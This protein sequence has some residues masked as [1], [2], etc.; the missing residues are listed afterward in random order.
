MSVK[1]KLNKAM[2]VNTATLLDERGTTHG[3]FPQQAT[4]AQC[5]K[6]IMGTSPN[7]EHMPPHRREALEMIATKLSRIC[8]GNPDHADH[9]DDIRGYAEL[10]K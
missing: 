2:V 7:W 3:N 10:G 5:I 8:Y 1:P 4:A 9:W 6:S